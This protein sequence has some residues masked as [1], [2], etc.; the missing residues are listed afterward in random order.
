M[1]KLIMLFFLSISLVG[2]K[3]NK[4]DYRL[5]AKGTKCEIDPNVFSK[6]AFQPSPPVT[7]D[8]IY[9]QNQYDM[10]FYYVTDVKNIIWEI[11][12]NDLINCK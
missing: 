5:L 3:K 8:S 11:P 6:G 10:L 7:V 1:K 9:K 12:D 4:L 2:C